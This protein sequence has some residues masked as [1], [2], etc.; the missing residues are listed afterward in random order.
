MT[1]VTEDAG[2]RV[3]AALGGAAARGL[4][5]VLERPDADRAARLAEVQSVLAGDKTVSIQWFEN[6]G[7]W[8]FEDQPE[9]FDTALS[10]FIDKGV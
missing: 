9:R 10:E 1:N 6:C 5:E 2:A 3:V 8:I 4:L 7:H